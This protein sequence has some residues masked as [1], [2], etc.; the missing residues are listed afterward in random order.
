MVLVVIRGNEEEKK[1]TSAELTLSEWMQALF[2]VF[3][4]S[5]TKTTLRG[6]VT[7]YNSQSSA[8]AS[9][10]GTAMSASDLCESRA[11]VHPTALTTLPRKKK[12][13]HQIIQALI[14]FHIAAYSLTQILM[15]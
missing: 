8:M 10:P 12:R 2:S 4:M 13:V 11:Q 15:W 5:G 6:G 3:C 1:L 9:L 7:F 14:A